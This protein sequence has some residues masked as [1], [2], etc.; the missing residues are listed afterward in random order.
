MTMRAHAAAVALLLVAACGSPKPESDSIAVLSP[1]DTVK[2]AP[3]ADSQPAPD[4]AKAVPPPATAAKATG[5]KTGSTK[6]AGETTKVLGRDSVIMP[7]PGRGLP[8]AKPDSL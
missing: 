4:T 8:P 2:A 1:V 7:K 3:A 5:T 6:T